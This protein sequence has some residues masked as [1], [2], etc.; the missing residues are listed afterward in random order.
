M[1]DYIYVTTVAA[2]RPS[3]SFVGEAAN[4]RGDCWYCASFC[5]CCVIAGR[6][7]VFAPVSPVGTVLSGELDLG[8]TSHGVV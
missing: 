1:I 5:G 4:V 7:F 3:D 2:R 6:D 8:A